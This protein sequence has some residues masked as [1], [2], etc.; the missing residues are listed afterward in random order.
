MGGVELQ[1]LERLGAISLTDTNTLTEKNVSG[2]LNRDVAC[3]LVH[4]GG[5]DWWIFYS[6]QQAKLTSCCL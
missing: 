6:L 4:F 3:Y 1:K 2:G 5:A